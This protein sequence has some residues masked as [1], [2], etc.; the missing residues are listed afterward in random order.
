MATNDS[1]S[2]LKERTEKPS[3][4]ALLAADDFT[5]YIDQARAITSLLPQKDDDYSG[6]IPLVVENAT[7]AV[8]DLLGK[9]SLAFEVVYREAYR[10]PS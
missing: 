7:W 3:T 5:K 10:K 1:I 8:N 2:I 9:A 4:R 6:L